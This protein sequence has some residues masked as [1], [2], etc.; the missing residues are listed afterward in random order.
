[1]L[2][3]DE[4]QERLKR[5]EQQHRTLGEVAQQHQAQETDQ[6]QTEISKTIK[7]QNDAI[8]GSG[9]LGELTQPHLVLA[10][11]VG[12]EG[13][14]AE[15]IHLHSGQH[16]ALTAERDLSHSVGRNW[17]A[18]IQQ[19]LTIFIHRMGAR[20]IAAMGV[21]RVEAEGDEL[22][23]LGQKKVT[24]QSYDDWVHITAK[25]GIVLNGG[26][27]YVKIWPGGLEEGT[28]SGWTAHAADHVFDSPKNME[29]PNSK[30]VVC[31]ECLKKAAREASA[32]KARE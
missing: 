3:T 8:A 5:A 32:L 6:D 27:S 18:A 22:Q 25:E 16:T 28:D 10:S 19:K 14:A 13:T 1:M 17:Y 21:I 20:I 23:L 12:I 30:P 11:P 7:A 31:E 2:A 15:S 9:N 24:L 4:T 26:G 29:V